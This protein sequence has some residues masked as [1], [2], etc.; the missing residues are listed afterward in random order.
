MR[1]VASTLRTPD[2]SLIFHKAGYRATSHV[3]LQRLA[4]G[5][6]LVTALASA[7]NAG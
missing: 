5:L 3:T 2:I 6:G 7:C 1:P 4:C